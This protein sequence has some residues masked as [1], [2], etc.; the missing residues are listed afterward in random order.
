MSRSRDRTEDFKDAVRAAALSS[1]YTESKLAAILAS[2]IMHKAPERKPFTRA[3]LKTLSSINELE[4]F[5]VKHRK[6]YVGFHR[7]TE[8]QRDDIEH[9]VSIFIK[10]CKD[11]IDFLKN[12]IHEEE[13]NRT[14]RKWLH[15]R[16][17]GSNA[18]V[19]AHKHGVVL[20]LSERLH[21]VT[22]LFDRLRSVRF[23][24]AVNKAMP[25]RKMHKIGNLKSSE[26][27]EMSALYHLMSTH[28]LQQ[29]QQ[30]EQLYEQAV[31]ATMNVERANQLIDTKY[32]HY[33]YL[34]FIKNLSRSKSMGSICVPFCSLLWMDLQ[35]VLG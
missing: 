31:A 23:Q 6:D 7:T 4:H 20:I 16:D 5:I 30:I 18:D 10:S 33:H 35:V 28:V 34:L 12:G 27:V 2:F 9:E 22:A 24:D 13:K 15:T 3:A 1:G 32:S 26:M 14:A 29:A 25:R 8:Q 19:V 11:Q 17:D 21:A